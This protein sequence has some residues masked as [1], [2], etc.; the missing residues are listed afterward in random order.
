MDRRTLII[1]LACVLGIR[2][3]GQAQTIAPTKVADLNPDGGSRPYAMK[4]GGAASD[5][6]YFST[7]MDHGAQGYVCGIHSTNGTAEG[8]STLFLDTKKVEVSQ[9]G[10]QGLFYKRHTA[11]AEYTFHYLPPATQLVQ[12]VLPVLEFVPQQQPSADRVTAALYNGKLIHPS[13]KDPALGYELY[14]MP[15]ALHSTA[16]L[17]KDMAPGL[18]SGL[19]HEIGAGVIGVLHNKVYLVAHVTG[20]G[21]E[22]WSTNGTAAGTVR[23]SD[24]HESASF[25]TSEYEVFGDRLFMNLAY[26]NG[27]EELFAILDSTSMLTKIKEINPSLAIGSRPQELTVLGRSLYFSADDG[28]KGRE[29]WKTD[30]TAAGTVL[31]KDINTIGGSDPHGL[32]AY[33]KLLYFF[34]KTGI[35]KGGEVLYSTDGTAANTKACVTLPVGTTGSAPMVC[36][37]KLFYVTRTTSPPYVSKLWRTSGTAAGTQ[38]VKAP[39]VV[40][41]DQGTTVTVPPD[42]A[43]STAPMQ[44][45]GNWLYFG[46]DF[47]AKGTELW[48][49]Q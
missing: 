28:T 17:I 14:T 42:D 43:I 32:V 8:T 10:T 21:T 13:K 19:S 47:D 35:G 30:G 41:P 26:A 33:G 34:A 11:W 16:T 31:V 44:V 18:S 39:I 9:I 25:F 38:Q 37:G 27:N 3:T 12:N 20:L 6:L 45:M 22:L 24:L 48:K 40:G 36:N 1:L 23:R 49:V 46:A 5:R 4:V 15:Q 29:L 7:V 2:S